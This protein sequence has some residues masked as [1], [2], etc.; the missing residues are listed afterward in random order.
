MNTEGPF[1]RTPGGRQE[2]ADANLLGVGHGHPR[3][4]R[5]GC[6]LVTHPTWAPKSHHGHLVLNA[7]TRCACPHSGGGG[8]G[9]RCTACGGD[10][11]GSSPSTP[12]GMTRGR[13]RREEGL[14]SGG[15]GGG[16]TPPRRRA[17]SRNLTRRRL[18]R[19][20]CT[21]KLQILYGPQTSG[22]TRV[23]LIRQFLKY[24]TSS[25]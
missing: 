4:D 6:Q 7:S 9:F 1:H 13:G 19:I 3:C 23:R 14:A 18:R 10:G 15:G 12:S 8:W 2:P 16:A 17:G 25:I 5:I 11:I 24:V 21:S 22:P 20:W